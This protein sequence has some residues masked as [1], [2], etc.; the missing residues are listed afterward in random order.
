MP[1]LICFLRSVV[2]LIIAAPWPAMAQD[3]MQ[4]SFSRSNQSIF[5]RG[6][7]DPGTVA[8]FEQFL[9]SHAVDEGTTVYF[10]SPGGSLV[11]GIQLGKV[12]RQRKLDTS[13]GA[14]GTNSG[15]CAS[16]CAIA[17]LGGVSRKVP[18]GTKYGVH[19]FRYVTDPT[20]ARAASVQVEQAQIASAILLQYLREM[21]VDPELYTASALTS[22]SSIS[23]LSPEHLKKWHVVTEESTRTAVTWSIDEAG[24]IT[25]LRGQRKQGSHTETLAFG[26]RDGALFLF[27][28]YDGGKVG[29]ELAQEFL[30]LDSERIR[31]A[32]LRAGQR[33]DDGAL[34]VT[35]RLSGDMWAKVRAAR[36][37]GISAQSE[38]AGVA[39]ISEIP[40]TKGIAERDQFAKR[41]MAAGQH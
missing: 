1:K 28:Y 24:G 18:A 4:F 25:Y 32:H 3:G 19:R 29:R 17:F 5:S 20:T 41:C 14:E 26:C 27:A 36:K 12:I 15:A 22:S 7:I 37:I 33:W 38:P 30:L 39:G 13:I 31:L 11:E 40:L 35:Y 9:D 16:A 10:H 34:V 23:F 8:R 2:V 6:R 21:G